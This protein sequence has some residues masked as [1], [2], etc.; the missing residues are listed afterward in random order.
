MARSHFQ[1]KLK[2]RESSFIAGALLILLFLMPGNRN[3]LSSTT[4]CKDCSRTAFLKRATS[5]IPYYRDNE[6][7]LY[8]STLSRLVESL[9]TP[10]FH[11][12]N[13]EVIEDLARKGWPESS[14]ALSGFQVPEYFLL[15][16]FSRIGAASGKAKEA[17]GTRLSLELVYNGEPNETVFKLA[18]ESPLEDYPSH[19]NRMYQNRDAVINQAKPIDETLQNFE[20]RPATCEVKLEGGDEAVP[21]ETVDV[22][23]EGF[24]DENGR[25]SREFN[26]VVVEARR[27]LIKGGTPVGE[28]ASRQAFRVGDGTVRLQYIAPAECDPTGDEITVYSSCDILDPGKKPMETTSI[29][30]RIASR[31]IKLICAEGV[32]TYSYFYQ[33]PKVYKEATIEIGLGRVEFS[34]PYGLEGN[35]ADYHP[36][37]YMK[38]RNAK[39]LKEGLPG[40]GFSFFPLVEKTTHHLVVTNPTSRK[41]VGVLIWNNL[42]MFKWS[43]GGDDEMSQHCAPNLSKPAE[44][45]GI[46][47]VSG[48]CTQR[49]GDAV[50]SFKWTLNRIARSGK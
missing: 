12:I 8:A 39:A 1:R 11:L 48:G 29:N 2:D 36:I 4:G 38:I 32:L 35:V 37:L 43:D 23:L 44:G 15:V 9:T 31:K 46:N 20:R 49:T 25:P 17:G 18:S 3:T 28:G 34:L 19:V 47:R 45:D 5:D 30:R 40:H 33:S 26:R 10:C 27:G 6:Q 7:I 41:A 42:V 50:E 13:R 16:D 21:W 24:K 14:R 22:V